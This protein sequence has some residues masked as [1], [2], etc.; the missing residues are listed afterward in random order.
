M[1]ELSTRHSVQGHT[2][3]VASAG[4][5]EIAP[6]TTPETMREGVRCIASLDLLGTRGEL[7]IEHHGRFYRLRVTQNDKLILTA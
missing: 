4:A 5:P 3:E 6:G 1:N 2:P 7:M